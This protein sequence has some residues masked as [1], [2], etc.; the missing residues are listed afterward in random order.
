M[1]KKVHIPVKRVSDPAMEDEIVRGAGQ[2]ETQPVE[3]PAETTPS[4]QEGAV[5]AVPA[6]EEQMEGTV[7][8]KDMALRLRAEMENYRKRQQRLAEEQV[9]REKDALLRKFLEVV[10]SLDKAIQHLDESDP[11]YE[12]LKVT[13]DL[14]QSLLRSEGVEVIPSVGR[15]FDPTLHEATAVV[16]AA[17]SQEAEMVV[18]DEDRRGYRVGG[19]VLRPARVVVAKRS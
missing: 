13:Y 8:W 7:D 15:P 2:E 19:R 3:V 5:E 1:A 6:E 12:G 18:V 17:E 4:T 14:M 11:A 9:A 10:D 16:P